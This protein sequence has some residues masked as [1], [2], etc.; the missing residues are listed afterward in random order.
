MDQQQD[1]W[2]RL[3][4]HSE[5]FVGESLSDHFH[6]SEV[7]HD[8][9]ELFQSGGQPP[10]LAPT[11]EITATGDEF[12]PRSGTGELAIRVSV[13]AENCTQ[14]AG[15]RLRDPQTDMRAIACG[16]AER[17]VADSVV[18]VNLSLGRFAAAV[19]VLRLID[20]GCLVVPVWW[21]FV[22]G[23]GQMSLWTTRCFA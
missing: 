16:L 23:A 22:Q 3:V 5:Q 4:P 12:D 9:A 15:R 2:V 7:E 13:L 11:Q 10:R 18:D 21:E 6:A 8:P 19:R 1:H 17:D 14:V 20:A